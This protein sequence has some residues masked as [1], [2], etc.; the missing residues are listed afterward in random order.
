MPLSTK[1]Q[2]TYYATADVSATEDITLGDD[3]V[4]AGIPI[5]A[6]ELIKFEAVIKFTGTSG[7]VALQLP[8]GA[9]AF[10]VAINDGA[11]E[12]SDD[13]TATFADVD[14]TLHLSGTIVNGAT[15]GAIDVQWAQN[16]SDVTATVRK[17]GSFISIQRLKYN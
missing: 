4:L 11:L 15:A 5:A 12:A 3:A 2:Y 16:V 10:G 8:A 7:Q 1:R 14:G 17:A 13:L 6:N 9:S